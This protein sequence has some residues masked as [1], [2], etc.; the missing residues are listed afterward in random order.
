MTVHVAVLS[1]DKTVQ[2]DLE[3]TTAYRYRI[4]TEIPTSEHHQR[5]PGPRRSGIAGRWVEV[6][7]A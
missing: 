2:L 6:V 1:R 5:T 4:E 7:T 3:L